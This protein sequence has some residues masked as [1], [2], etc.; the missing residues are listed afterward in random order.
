M[1]ATAVSEL[2]ETK[3]AMFGFVH[4]DRRGVRQSGAERLA[5]HLL[6]VLYH[7]GDFRLFAHEVRRAGLEASADALARLDEWWHFKRGGAGASAAVAT[8]TVMQLALSAGADRLIRRPMRRLLEDLVWQIVLRA[9]DVP[10]SLRFR[11]IDAD[12][13]DPV[14]TWPQEGMLTAVERGTLPEWRR[15]AEVLLRDPYGEVA[16]ALKQAIETAEDDGGAAVMAIVLE[17]AGRGASG[18]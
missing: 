12:P 16:A 8:D 15:I 11:N 10:T 2:G 14:E 18:H 7:R 4:R 9:P 5:G 1:G 13:S 3:G 17:R 6:S